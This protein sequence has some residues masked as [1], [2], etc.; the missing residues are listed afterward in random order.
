[1]TKTYGKVVNV[2][3][4][5][6]NLCFGRWHVAVVMEFTYLTVINIVGKDTA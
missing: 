4:V 1:M 3:D 2:S 5:C 6:S